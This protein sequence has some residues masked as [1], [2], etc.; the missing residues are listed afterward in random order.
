MQELRREKKMSEPRKNQILVK[1]AAFS[2]VTLLFTNIDELEK[3]TPIILPFQC[4]S[5]PFLAFLNEYLT[6]SPETNIP[7]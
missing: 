3:F 6:P 1:L 7:P 5:P 2:T 4:P